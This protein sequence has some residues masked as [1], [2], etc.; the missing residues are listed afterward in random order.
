[1]QAHQREFLE[2]CLRHGVL[3]FG[4][5]VLKSGRVSPY[6]FDSGLFNTGGA[7]AA[8]GRCYAQAA[9]ASGIEFDMLFG[10]AYKGIPLVSVTAAALAS[11]LRTRSAVRV[12]P[13]GSERPWRGRRTDRRSARRSRAHRR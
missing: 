8:L 1:M 5:F 9:I 10:P 12:Q 13:Q 6:F 3:R 4:E 7:L 2:L 11:S